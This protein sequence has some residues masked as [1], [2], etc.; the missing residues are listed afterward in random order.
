MIGSFMDES[1][2]MSQK[3]IFAVGG[4]MG[5]GVATFELERRWNRLRQRPDIDIRYFK[6][7]ECTFGKGEFAKFVVDPTNI[8][9]TERN[10]LN[11]IIKMKYEPNSYLIVAGVGVVQDDFYGVIQDSYARSV[12]GDSPYFLA[13]H[14]AMIQCAWAVKELNTGDYVSF[15]CDECERYSA[16]A[17]ESF[18]RLKE[19]NPKAA[20]H[21]ATYSSMDEKQCEPL[22]AADAV[23]YE[24]RRV[25]NLVLGQRE[26]HLRKQFSVLDDAKAIF[27]VQ[28]ANKEHLLRIVGT[29]KP[30]EP[31]K[32][33]EIMDQSFSDDI[34]FGDAKGSR[35]PKI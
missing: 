19:T 24:I 35:V 33:D 18:K 13:Y 22:Q 14:L 23:V 26:G 12:L 3:G 16:L 31:F 30:G 8:T 6:A 27:L 25:L 17:Y 9:S 11:S 4:L 1:F 7:S 21:M 28:N 20:A 10:R 15:V 5:R 32:L 2:D 29:H 34:R